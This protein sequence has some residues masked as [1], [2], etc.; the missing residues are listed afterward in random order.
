MGWI[1]LVYV[2]RRLMTKMM[3]WIAL[4]L[5]R[6]L[7]NALELIT[8]I[9]TINGVLLMAKRMELNYNTFIQVSHKCFGFNH[10]FFSLTKVLHKP[11]KPKGETIPLP[12][13]SIKHH[14]LNHFLPLFFE[15]YYS[16]LEAW[17][18]IVVPLSGYPKNALG[19]ITYFSTLCGISHK[20]TKT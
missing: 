20:P 13:Y 12:R 15:G 5:S 11:T 4:F 1:I 16:W 8:Y 3:E 9:L 7:G 10:L 2:I 18:K 19:S 6:Y 14:G 17:N